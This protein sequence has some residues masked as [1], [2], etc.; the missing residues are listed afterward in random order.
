MTLQL[1]SSIVTTNMNPRF[2]SGGTTPH[3]V[4]L[5]FGGGHIPQV[6]PMVGGWNPLSF[7]PNPRVSVPGWSAQMSGQFAS[8]ILFV[9][10]SSSTLILTNDF[11]M[12]HPPLS[13]SVPFRGS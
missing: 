8:Y 3:Y 2:G 7:K 4:P 1:S 5:S 10:L 13:F 11:I 9:S 6:N 12:A